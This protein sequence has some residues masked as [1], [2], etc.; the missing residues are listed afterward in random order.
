MGYPVSWN[1]IPIYTCQIE[2][3]LSKSGSPFIAK[4]VRFPAPEIA[5]NG[6]FK[7]PYN[8]KKAPPDFRG[9]KSP[10]KV[11]FPAPK[12]AKNGQ[13]KVPYNS[14]Q[15]SSNLRGLK[16]PKRCVF[17]RQK[18]PKCAR[19]SISF[20]VCLGCLKAFKG[21]LKGVSKGCSMGVSKALLIYFMAV[22]SSL[23]GYL[24]K[25]S[26]PSLRGGPQNCGLAPP[27][28][29]WFCPIWSFFGTFLKI[30][31]GPSLE[32]MKMS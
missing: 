9:L 3:T 20:H 31:L 21:Y 5:K 2:R 11:R 8:S 23:H 18:T 10:K 17:R 26:K 14:K 32:S 16:T 4:Q 12:I 13:F 1:K 25:V 15:A 29:L 6:Q 7:A 24:G 22:L 28:K 30:S 27:R 19:D